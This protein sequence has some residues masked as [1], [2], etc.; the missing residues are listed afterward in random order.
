[1][2]DPGQLTFLLRSKDKT[3]GEVTDSEDWGQDPKGA[4]RAVQGG[5]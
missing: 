2:G 1:M 5:L 3:G 4:E